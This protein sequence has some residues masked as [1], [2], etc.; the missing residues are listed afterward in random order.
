VIGSR[1]GPFRE[2]LRA[3]SEKTVDV[4]SLIH[5]RMKLDQGVEAMSIAAR[6]GVLKV[7]LTME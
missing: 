3:L 1:C 2:A 4:T 7:L 5:R 6:P